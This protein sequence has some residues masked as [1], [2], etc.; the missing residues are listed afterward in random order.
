MA[1]EYR[2][3]LEGAIP[4]DQMAEY[5]MLNPTDRA[6]PAEMPGL[7]SADLRD[8]QSFTLIVRH[9]RDG[10][11]EADDDGSDWAWELDV[12]VNLTF[13]MA[14]EGDAETGVRNMLEAVSRLLAGR[15]EDAALILNGDVLLLTRS[16][17]VLRKHRRELWWNRYGFVNDVIPD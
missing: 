4:L 15:P 13:R 16:S 17:G 9:G 1:I 11:Y 14:K 10:Y 2:L 7:L 5:V 8:R 6:V 3:T 12:Y